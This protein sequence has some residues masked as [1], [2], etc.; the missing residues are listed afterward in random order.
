MKVSLEDSS[1]SANEICFLCL[2][3]CRLVY[4]RQCCPRVTISLGNTSV[5]TSLASWLII[6]VERKNRI[7]KKVLW[8]VFGPGGK[9]KT[10]KAGVQFCDSKN[11]EIWINININTFPFCQWVRLVLP[12][13]YKLCYVSY[14]ISPHS[15]TE[16]NV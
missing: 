6:W 1:M 15:L 3:G 11:I 5:E 8:T 2:A 13:I 12:V 7:K 4:Y 10:Q 14:W 9:N 16:L